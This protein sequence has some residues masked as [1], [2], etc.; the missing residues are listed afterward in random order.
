MATVLATVTVSHNQ[1]GSEMEE[2]RVEVKQGER[3]CLCHRAEVSE[4]SNPM[5][6]LNFEKAVMPH[7]V[8]AAPQWQCQLVARMAMQ[9]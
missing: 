4:G 1:S 9:E 3:S 8:H 6:R 7:C 2:I 5:L